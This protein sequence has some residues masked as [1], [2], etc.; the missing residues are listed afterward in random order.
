MKNAIITLAIF[1]LMATDAA[2][3]Q[4]KVSVT[5]NTRITFDFGQALDQPRL[6]ATNGKDIFVSGNVGTLTSY[7]AAMA[8]FDANGKK[9]WQAS[10]DTLCAPSSSYTGIVATAD[11][12][13][14]WVINNFT[15]EGFNGIIK[16]DSNGREQW[17]FS[18]PS[19]SVQAKGD[20]TFVVCPNVTSGLFYA[21]DGK[22]KLLKSDSL[23]FAVVQPTFTVTGDYVHLISKDWNR[24]VY[25]NMSGYVA[26]VNWKTGQKIW[27]TEFPDIDAL[28]GTSDDSGNTYIA[29]STTTAGY[30]G[31]PVILSY[32]M[33]GIDSN[34]SV[35]WKKIWAPRKS[36][37]ANEE[38]W[39]ENIVL[40]QDQVI[41]V[42]TIQRGEGQ[43]DGYY[44]Y[45]AFGRK[46]TNGD[47]LWNLDASFDSGT[48]V[49]QLGGGVFVGDE[50]LLMGYSHSNFYGNPPNVGY[51]TSYSIITP[52]VEPKLLPKDFFLSQNYPNPFNPATSIK[53]QVA[54][55]QYI[56]LMVYNI[57]GQ[58]VATLVDGYQS[59]GEHQVTFDSSKLPS[60]TYFYR[61]Q[62][63]SFSETKKMM[64]MK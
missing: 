15:Q 27:S 36:V 23:A 63:G 28:Y 45:Y 62:A 53:Y 24:G 32:L 59:L 50:L 35:T 18:C 56:T 42:G 17:R 37:M 44:N 31:Y 26:K 1:L 51:L 34:G 10:G 60:G 33:A 19:A 58:K 52:V 7:Y 5:V 48:I 6:V 61:L 54:S 12:G 29:A 38:N 2:V 55:R 9:L 20:T 4:D 14:I 47:S 3:S 46:T 43:N 13:T 49:D 57:L 40:G 39:A 21:L 11:G 25:A 22:G 41:L 64:L 30:G 8:K 16:L